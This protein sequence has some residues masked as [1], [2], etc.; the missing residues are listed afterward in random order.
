MRPT[1]VFICVC[2]LLAAPAAARMY[3]W[4][5]PATGTTQLSGTPPAWYRSGD[6]GPRVYVF[7][8]NQLVDDT[9]IT[10]SDEQRAALR[11]EAFGDHHASREGTS[12]APAQDSAP[13]GA[14]D[15]PPT[16]QSATRSADNTTPTDVVE[17]AKASKA[18]SL[19]AL[20]DAWDQRQLDE[21][22]SLLD[23]LPSESKTAPA[24]P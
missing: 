4:H 8:N 16:P 14:E 12:S 9:G 7:E 10:V 17:T 13:A 23:M 1:L 24:R 6:P 19:K 20:I 15:A 3:Q 18:A 22:R 2:C 21:A 11:D 5:N